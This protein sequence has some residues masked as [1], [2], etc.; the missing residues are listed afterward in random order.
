M[1]LPAAAGYLKTKDN[2]VIL[3]RYFGN[4]E[5]RN[6]KYW[7]PAQRTAGMTDF[8]ACFVIPVKTGIQ[9]DC[10]KSFLQLKYERGKILIFLFLKGRI[11][12]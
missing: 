7:I 2:A 8:F 4:A 3:S 1:N 9:K 12:W 10:L 6:I 11:E 5:S